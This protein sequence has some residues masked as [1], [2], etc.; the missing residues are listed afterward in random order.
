MQEQ[1]TAT[2]K[3]P[4]ESKENL[5]NTQVGLGRKKRRVS[6]AVSNMATTESPALNCVSSFHDRMSNM[7]IMDCL[8]F[9]QLD[10]L[11]LSHFGTFN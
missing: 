4:R 2:D 3:V 7:D 9:P 11:V 5:P 8:R 10:S 6:P 1:N